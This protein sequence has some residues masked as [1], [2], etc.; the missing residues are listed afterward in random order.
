[1]IKYPYIRIEQ[2]LYDTT[3][4]ALAVEA[5]AISVLAVEAADAIS[6]GLAVSHGIAA[7]SD[8]IILIQDAL[9]AANTRL[10]TASTTDYALAEAAANAM[11]IV[12]NVAIA[13][14]ASSDEIILMQDAL[15]IANGR[16]ITTATDAAAAKIA[17][18]TQDS[19]V[20]GRMELPLLKYRLKAVLV[21][22]LGVET[23]IPHTSN[24][25]VKSMDDNI[26]VEIV[27]DNNEVITDINL[28]AVREGTA[29][30]WI[31][32]TLP[33]G[34][35][36]TSTREI[37][38]YNPWFR[39]NYWKLLGEYDANE[40]GTGTYADILMQSVMEMFDVLWAYGAD[41]N[42]ITDPIFAKKKFV[43][44]IGKSIGFPRTDFQDDG[45]PAEYAANKLYR[46]LIANLW[47]LLALRGTRMSYEMFFGA[48]GYDLELLEFWYNEDGNLVEIK[49]YNDADS[50]FYIYDETGKLINENQMTGTD[51]RVKASPDNAWNYCCKSPYIKPVFTP[52][53]GYDLQGGY[54]ISQRNVIKRY[55]EFLRPEHVKYLS[56]VIGI[57]ITDNDLNPDILGR[58]TD[59]EFSY[60]NLFMPFVW[61]NGLYVDV[62]SESV[63]DGDGMWDPEGDANTETGVSNELTNGQTSSLL[64]IRAIETFDG[65]ALKED[66]LEVSLLAQ[67]LVFDIDMPETGCTVKYAVVAD[68]NNIGTPVYTTIVL[69]DNPDAVDHIVIALP[70]KLSWADFMTCGVLIYAQ[71]TDTV[72][73]TISNARI[74]IC[75]V[76]TID[77]DYVTA[78]NRLSN[79][80]F[81]LKDLRPIRT[82]TNG[83]TARLPFMY[84]NNAE[85]KICDF[86]STTVITAALN[87][88]LTVDYTGIPI[89]FLS[90]GTSGLLVGTIYYFIYID[91][92]TFSIA[93]SYAEAILGTAATFVS[94]GIGEAQ[95]PPLYLDAG[96]RAIEA[97]PGRLEYTGPSGLGTWYE[98]GGG[99]AV[100]EMRL[101]TETFVLST[102][103]QINEQNMIELFLCIMIIIYIM[104]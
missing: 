2:C 93:N 103:V 55:L 65:T 29:E 50:T 95:F 14:T 85:R 64:L 26:F 86:A 56:E 23:E 69:D 43:D 40:I 49:P 89:S 58:Q 90:V 10:L 76:K 3:A 22:S 83:T 7:S 57:S 36:I 62:V 59:G 33:G 31:Y 52:K 24:L 28:Y 94:G 70:E 104:I 37:V 77:I 79:D 80:F 74:N 20:T 46:E 4:L 67:E 72:D 16:I 73:I 63:S 98:S 92:G 51:P 100:D 60:V 54:S 5:V 48:L 97:N 96:G 17:S 19:S 27:K 82:Y 9:L 75:Y 30:I 78:V 53:D 66:T 39:D 32:Y 68:Y 41:L 99:M 13:N 12:L 81:V 15:L 84:T 1:M 25:V 38:V 61:I 101:F 102:P 71:A 6:I 47:D 45:T 88:E 42:E 34:S 35:L 8:E 91:G 87:S 18:Y 44:T 21:T 11:Q